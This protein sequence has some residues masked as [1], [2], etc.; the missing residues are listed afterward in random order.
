MCKGNIKNWTKLF[1]GAKF[2]KEGTATLPPT[3]PPYSSPKR[4]YLL[5]IPPLCLYI[6]RWEGRGR[7]GK[8]G[9][10][11]EKRG[12]LQKNRILQIFVGII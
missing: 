6:I 8:E 4:R 9:K 3:L 5:K 2:T 11:E 12:F 10:R 7:E 1:G